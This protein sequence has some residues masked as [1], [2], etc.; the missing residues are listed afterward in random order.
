LLRSSG[1][2]E[3]RK[4]RY[5]VTLYDA[6]DLAALQ[7]L[8]ECLVDE[9]TQLEFTDQP[10]R[11]FLSDRWQRADPPLNDVIAWAWNAGLRRW[12]PR[13]ASDEAAVRAPAVLFG[14][15]AIPAMGL[16]ASA[17]FGRGPGAVAALSS[18]IASMRQR[19]Y[20]SDG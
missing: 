19:G 17:A 1:F 16:A 6:L 20:A 2:F 10:L 15:L 11:S 9:L 14:V 8:G 4:E 3:W 13:R 12:A 7:H 18:A 5:A